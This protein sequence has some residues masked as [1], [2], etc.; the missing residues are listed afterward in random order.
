VFANAAT[1]DTMLT[2]VAG[3][4][5]GPGEPSLVNTPGVYRMGIFVT[6]V[7]GVSLYRHTG[8]WGTVAGYSPELDL[9]LA[10]VV[11]QRDGKA[12]LGE[13][14][15]GVLTLARAADAEQSPAGDR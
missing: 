1:L 12:L 3:A 11:T 7:D 6:G 13:L 8:Y 15:K 10:A 2:T 5:P 9:A 4:R 14:E